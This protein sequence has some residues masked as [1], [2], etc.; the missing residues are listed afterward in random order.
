MVWTYGVQT[1]SDPKSGGKIVQQF[2]ER[3][4]AHVGDERNGAFFSRFDA[5][6]M[7][8]YSRKSYPEVSDHCI[9][10]VGISHRSDKL[11]Q[12]SFNTT[13]YHLV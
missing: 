1:V 13:G 2:Q 4:W 8:I 6:H 5:S 9:R 10:Q 7:H 12:L 3:V 11:I